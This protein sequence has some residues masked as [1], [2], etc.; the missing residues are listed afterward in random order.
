MQ[1][2]Q[3][4]GHSG[5]AMFLSLTRQLIY[6]LPGLIIFPRIYGL[7]GVWIAMPVADV[8]SGVTAI[9]MILF[10]MPRIRKTYRRVEPNEV[11]ENR[12]KQ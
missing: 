12:E 10:F 2:F 4:I 8:L 9:G 1:F 6:L 3:G 5:K 7:M 11:P